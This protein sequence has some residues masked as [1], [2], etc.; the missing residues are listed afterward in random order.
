MLDNIDFYL[1]IHVSSQEKDHSYEGW[2]GDMEV[3]NGANW[4]SLLQGH[5]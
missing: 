3:E 4:K 5:K 2:G 1:K